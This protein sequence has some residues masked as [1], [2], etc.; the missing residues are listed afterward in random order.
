MVVFCQTETECSN[1]RHNGARKTFLNGKLFK[2]IEWLKCIIL[3][4]LGWLSYLFKKSNPNRT[5]LSTFFPACCLFLLLSLSTLVHH[6]L[7]LLS[8]QSL[9]SEHHTDKKQKLW[10]PLDFTSHATTPAACW[11]G[12][13]R[14]RAVTSLSLSQIS[15]HSKEMHCTIEWSK[16]SV[17]NTL[18]DGRPQIHLERGQVVFTEGGWR[19]HLGWQFM[20]RV[21]LNP[22]EILWALLPSSFQCFSGWGH[23]LS[24]RVRN[25]QLVGCFTHFCWCLIGIKH[26]MF[27]QSLSPCMFKSYKHV[28]WSADT[29]WLCHRRSSSVFRVF[30]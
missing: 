8:E 27:S 22:W 20:T 12:I 5:V 17:F 1:Y 4:V 16:E 25:A 23:G 3:C 13:S 9:T 19:R 30:R 24:V 11:C 21:L 7:T 2:K 6:T 14:E 15:P 10:L 28:F 26:Y 18:Q 29:S